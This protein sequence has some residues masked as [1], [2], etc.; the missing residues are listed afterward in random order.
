M[1]SVEK[2]S[3]QRARRAFRPAP[4]RGAPCTHPGRGAEATAS[5]AEL[6]ALP[7]AAGPINVVNSS[8]AH[9]RTPPPSLRRDITRRACEAER[10]RPPAKDVARGSGGRGLGDTG[11]VHGIIREHRSCAQKNLFNRSSP[12]SARQGHQV[13][14]AAAPCPASASTPTA[15]RCGGSWPR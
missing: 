1:G 8:R 13:S 14:P 15:C 5:S 7:A 11:H 2:R 10:P 4:D 6:R 9:L 3:T 12:P